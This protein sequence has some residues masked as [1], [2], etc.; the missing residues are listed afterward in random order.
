MSVANFI[1]CRETKKAVL[2]GKGNYI[3]SNITNDLTKFLFDHKG[4]ELIFT[5]DSDNEELLD[6]CSTDGYDN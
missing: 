3:F 6:E 1:L 2:V 4:R 5:N